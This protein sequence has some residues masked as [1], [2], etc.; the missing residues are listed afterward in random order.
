MSTPSRSQAEIGLSARSRINGRLMPFLFILYIIAFLDRVNVGYA[1]LQ[2]TRD[3][4]F[5]A[6]IF[7]FGS[8][9]FFFGYLLLEIPGSVLVERW[10]ARK[11][12]ARIMITWGVLAVVMAFVR[13]ASEFYTIRFLL[14]AAEAG[15][16]PGIIVY[17]S[18]WFRYEDRAKAVA[19]FMAA[20]PVSNLL[21]SPI[22]GLLLGV[23]WLGLAG[24]RWL[25]IVEGGPAILLGVITLYYLTDWPREAT[26]L[27]DEEKA[28]I[29]R[30]LEDEK[31]AR[32]AVKHY[33]MW[34]ALR[35]RDVLLLVGAYFF[36][37]VG[38]YGFTFF[39]PTMLKQ[40]SGW[41]DLRFTMVAII[42]HLAGLFSMILVGRSSDRS[43]ERRW[44]CA[45]A[46][47][48]GAVGYGLAILAGG[49]P[50]LVVG[51][52]TIIAIGSEGF[53]PAFWPIPTGFLTE[54][55]AAAAIGLINSSGNM[56]GFAGPFILG[57][58]S[59]TT[60]SFVGG[61]AVLSV[62][63]V[64]GAVCVLSVRNHQ[65]GRAHV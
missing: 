39:L 20:I 41:S 61:L 38:F 42:P 58:A 64:L 30:E 21:G 63:L 13:S 37:L 51:A 18:H 15:F 46:M 25:F 53:M 16:F 23:N 11:W 56:G 8:G 26:W 49:S 4:G 32:K 62:S 29:T 6:E 65:I 9:I 10:S 24:W 40:A 34:E 48:T 55:A 50:W 14:G 12:I 60:N 36:A 5:S 54:S 1:A 7:G 47:V 43:G 31:R 19:T 3:L 45:L 35:H 17:L 44:H 27:P 33:S 28:W 52:F 57:Y 2:M 22:S 59:T